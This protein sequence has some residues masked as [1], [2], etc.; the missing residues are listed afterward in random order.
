MSKNNSSLIGQWKSN[1]NDS[2]T[3]KYYGNVVMDF[4]QNGE[5]IYKINSNK[6][7]QIICMIYEIRDNKLITDQPSHKK[8]I[9]TRFIIKDN[10]L[11]LYY[12]GIKSTYIRD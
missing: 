6:K 4:K 5:L 7:Y 10:I 12:D 11:E 1:P 8:E 2:L 9:S 3:T